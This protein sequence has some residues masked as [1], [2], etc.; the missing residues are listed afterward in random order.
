MQYILIYN[1]KMISY[2]STYLCLLAWICTLVKLQWSRSYI[3]PPTLIYTVAW[4]CSDNIDSARACT[5]TTIFQGF[6]CTQIQVGAL[7]SDSCSYVYRSVVLPWVSDGGTGRYILS[8]ALVNIV[9][10]S[11]NAPMEVS[12]ACMLT[13]IYSRFTVFLID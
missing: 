8:H 2:Q 10:C 9:P 1:Q 12:R 7:C 11:F 6:L 5:L 3:R 4:S 13:I